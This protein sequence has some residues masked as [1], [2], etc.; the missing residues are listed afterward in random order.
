MSSDPF[1][2]LDRARGELLAELEAADEREE[3]GEELDEEA[4][5]LTTS[6][7]AFTVGA[8]PVLE[9]GYTF[10]PNWH[11]DAIVEHLEACSRREIQRLIINIPPG[12]MKS[13]NVS[14]LWP[15]WWWTFDPHIRFLTTSYGEKL[16]T[17]DALKSRRL[18]QSAWFRARFGHVFALTGDQNQKT[19]Y[20]NDKTGY[21]IAS[22]VGGT[23][24]GERADVVLIDDPHNADEVESDT[25]RENVLDW[26]DG[27][28]P[29]RLNE[30]EKGV[31]VLVMQR[32]HESDLAGHLLARGGWE[33]LCLPAEYEPN[34]PF[35]WP[36]DPRT[37]PGELLWPDH[38]G[39]AALD[40]LKLEM[41][42]YRV[43]GQLQ[44]RPAPA[45]GGILKTGWWRYYD[46]D[47]LEE[48]TLEPLATILTFWDTALKA[49]TTSDYC[50]GTVWGAAGA[51]RYLL[52]RVRDRMELPDTIAAVAQ[53]AEW[54]EAK[55][56]HIPHQIKVE[57]AANG[58]EVVAKL[59][60]SITGISLWSP[61]DHGDK[62][63]RAHAITPELHAGQ[64]LVPGRG[65]PGGLGPDPTTPAW[66]VDLIGECSS[67]PNGAHDDQVDSVT[68]ALLNLRGNLR[69]PLRQ[70]DD[71]A[72]Q[73]LRR[74]V[75]A[76]IAGKQ[77]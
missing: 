45:E 33:H 56:P 10:K 65:L 37:T 34:H 27:T 24:T 61:R 53:L 22:S 18:I 21:R 42:P 26:H 4:R 70:P 12:H 77:F 29:T 73:R 30:P 11:I 44:Q 46:A 8:W 28:I 74:Q 7:R 36:R 60:S 32:L 59:R 51:N 43:A 15:V 39:Q 5:R 40:E 63:Q 48:W 19:R 41:G 25:Q 52:R 57:A 75:S 47:N 69:R 55:F 16:A 2:E 49:K 64:V 50:V 35:V 76:G 6:L 20:E 23:G 72:S 68:G 9:P 71:P 3:R 17:R 13:L 1:A 67:F 31:R 14:V 66:V 54:V 38:I 62:V 58:P